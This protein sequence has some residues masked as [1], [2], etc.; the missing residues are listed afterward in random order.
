MSWMPEDSILLREKTGWFGEHPYISFAIVSVL[1][2]VLFLWL[3]KHRF[4]KRKA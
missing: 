3:R 4:D 2:I 1:I